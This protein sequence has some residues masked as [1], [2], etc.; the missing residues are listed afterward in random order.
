MENPISHDQNHEGRIGRLEGIVEQI[1]LR[2]E[3]IERRMDRRF[4]AMERRQESQFRWMVGLQVTSILAVC[5]LI[6]TVLSRLP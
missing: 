2:L 4:D 3:S 1:N 5:T 6:L